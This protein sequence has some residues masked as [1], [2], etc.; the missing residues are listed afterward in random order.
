MW[1]ADAAVGTRCGSAFRPRRSPPRFGPQKR[2]ATGSGRSPAGP[3]SPHRGRYRS[4]FKLMDRSRQAG[5][6]VAPDRRFPLAPDRIDQWRPAD[7]IEPRRLGRGRG[8]EA[9]PRSPRAGSS[10]RAP[11]PLVMPGRRVATERGLAGE[12]PLPPA[13]RPRPA[14]GP[15]TAPRRS[16]TARPIGR[17]ARPRCALPR[18]YFADCHPSASGLAIERP[19]AWSIAR[20]RSLLARA[21]LQRLAH[22]WLKNHGLPPSRRSHE[23]ILTCHPAK[24]ELPT[25]RGLPR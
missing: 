25:L 11:T 14:V 2:L 7:G 10:V 16:S 24:F 12:T 5:L 20:A 13:S 19:E 6:T 8:C 1:L 15:Y 22:C 9:A 23:R 21:I 4:A 18:P 3:E 17:A